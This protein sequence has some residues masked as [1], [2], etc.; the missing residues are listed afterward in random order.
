M[1]TFLQDLK[2]V[3]TSLVETLQTNISLFTQTLEM[4]RVFV[5][6]L[7]N[8]MTIHDLLLIICLTLVLQVRSLGQVTLERVFL[9]VIL[10]YLLTNSLHLQ[11]QSNPNTVQ[12]RY[13]AVKYLKIVTRVS[14][15]QMTHNVQI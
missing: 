6:D 2:L 9:L 5:Q 3:N 14:P 13:N 10:V 7:F 15:L 4:L 11:V 1:V 8:S 12:C